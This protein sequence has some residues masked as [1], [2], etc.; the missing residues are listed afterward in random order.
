MV[1]SEATVSNSKWRH[2]RYQ[3]S[4]SLC[5]TVLQAHTEGSFLAI[6]VVHEFI[7]D[8]TDDNKQLQN[9]KELGKILYVLSDG[10]VND[11]VSGILYDGFN[12]DGMDLMIGKIITDY[13]EYEKQ[14]NKTNKSRNS[15]TKRCYYS[16][17][18]KR[19]SDFT[20]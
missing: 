6:F 15:N 12:I 13:D 17:H 3:L 19:I 5:G 20:S 18:C 11:V 14:P 2:I 10:T 1:D 8:A 7:T 9:H 4:T 16:K